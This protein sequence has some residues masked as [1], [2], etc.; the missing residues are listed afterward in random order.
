MV[1]VSVA[2]SG[3]DG[4]DT[5]FDLVP[6]SLSTIHLQSLLVDANATEK[7]HAGDAEIVFMAELPPLGYS[8]FEIR[9]I[10][11]T[12]R[13]EM[14]CFTYGEND[15]DENFAHWKPSTIMKAGRFGDGRRGMNTDHTLVQKEDIDHSRINEPNERDVHVDNRKIS[16]A[17]SKENDKFVYVLSN[18]LVNLHFDKDTG[19]LTSMVDKEDGIS[20]P[21]DVSFISYNSSD[22]FE[23]DEDRGQASGAYIF[24]PNG[25]DLIQPK[26]KHLNL[27]IHNGHEVSEA[28]LTFTEWVHLIIRL[29]RDQKHVE[30]EWTVGPVPFKDGFGREIAVRY[31]SGLCSED[32]FWTDA[33]GRKMMPRRRNYRPTW[34]LNVTEPIAGN[35]YPVTAAAFIQDQ[36]RG[37]RL[38]VLVDRAQ[39][40]TSQNPGEL[41]FMIHRRI[42]HDDRR[43]VGEALNETL[44][45]CTDCDCPGLVVRGS[46]WLSLSDHSRRHTTRVLQQL[47]NDPPLLV[48]AP[49]QNDQKLFESRHLVKSFS[50]TGEYEMPRSTQLITLLRPMDSPH[51]LLVRLAHL[52][53]QEEIEQDDMLEYG[54]SHQEV[55]LLKIIRRFGCSRSSRVKELSLSTN[56][57]R[58]GMEE[59]RKRFKSLRDVENRIFKSYSKKHGDNDDP[60]KV[61]LH[62]MEIRTFEIEC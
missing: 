36:Q 13:H 11:G 28:K 21:L 50:L 41:E 51:V 58:K 29:H 61:R 12:K 37:S 30:F 17:S 31:S 9:P 2:H 26:E 47:R 32:V 46:H 43:G 40:A 5:Y 24:R 57:Q 8:A 39:A 27:Q 56:Q 38:T 6:V 23:T 34:N 42:L 14:D 55:D 20:T 18:G 16:F 48:F 54:R 62:P 1:I 44:C 3:P 19:R 7:D 59:H 52:Q 33:N 45:G 53:E 22:G 10:Y 15:S 60:W 35:F 49:L 25:E 4:E